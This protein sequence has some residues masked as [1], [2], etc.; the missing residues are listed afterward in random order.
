MGWRT[1]SREEIEAAMPPGTFLLGAPDSVRIWEPE[2]DETVLCVE[3]GWTFVP[4]EVLKID[5]ERP[6]GLS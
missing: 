3:A 1:P 2:D 6:D 5:V 4:G